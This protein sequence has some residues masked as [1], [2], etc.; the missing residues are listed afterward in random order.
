MYVAG[1]ILLL[2][3][4]VAT[5]INHRNPPLSHW[6]AHKIPKTEEKTEKKEYPE[7]VCQDCGTKA[8]NGKQFDISTWHKGVCGVCNETK[9]VT[10]PRDFHYPKFDQANTA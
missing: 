5:I 7:W 4:L 10:E 8:S 1:G 2:V 6:D 3:A 9:D